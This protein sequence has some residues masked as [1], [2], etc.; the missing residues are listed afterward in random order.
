MLRSQV[1]VNLPGGLQARN[2][3]YFFTTAS[4]F[5]CEIH[6]IYKGITCGIDLMDIM[7]LNVLE[8]D[9]VLL[10]ANGKDEKKAIST[11]EK[12]FSEGKLD[13]KS[14]NIP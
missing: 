13:N 1:T 10:V 14:L 11:L 4:L 12:F 5:D 7:N 8:K 2:T 6:I 9:E 3:C